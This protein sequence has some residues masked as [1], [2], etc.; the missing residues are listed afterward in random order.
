M[1]LSQPSSI[2]GGRC[3]LRGQL[4]WGGQGEQVLGGGE[5]KDGRRVKFAGGQLGWGQVCETP[6][7]YRCKE[8]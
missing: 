4:D 3:V 6:L 1:I 2:N 5:I 7:S 8:A